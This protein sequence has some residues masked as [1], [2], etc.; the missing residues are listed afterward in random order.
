MLQ[1]KLLRKWQ[2]LDT[3]LEARL[4]RIAC[5]AP[6]GDPARMTVGLRKSAD[7][8]GLGAPPGR[9]REAFKAGIN[10]PVPAVIWP[11]GGCGGGP[12]D[13]CSGK[14]FLDRLAEK[15]AG[16]PPSELPGFVH[17]LRMEALEA[18]GTHW[19]RDLSLLW[20]DPRALP[21]TAP[22]AASPVG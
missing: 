3:K 17:E 2:E 21:D 1:Y 12:H 5:G 15:L 11:R 10:A 18:G 13:A 22:F 16:L 9:A 20:E 6:P 4:H 19:A 14:E 7:L 8:L